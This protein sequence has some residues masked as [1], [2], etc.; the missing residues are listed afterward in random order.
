MEPRKSDSPPRQLSLRD[1]DLSEGTAPALAP[2][3]PPSL[4]SQGWQGSQMRA[5]LSALTG[6]LVCARASATVSFRPPSPPCLLVPLPKPLSP[7]PLSTAASPRCS[8]CCV[9]GA[10]ETSVRPAARAP[11][12]A[13]PAPSPPSLPQHVPTPWA[14]AAALRCLHRTRCLSPEHRARAHSPTLF[15]TPRGAKSSC[16][17]TGQFRAVK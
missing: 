10:G 11:D 15:L 12:L 17:Y 13:P 16:Q 5:T 4:Q 14:L 6:P 3:S 2:R 1:L 8:P 9:G 7:L